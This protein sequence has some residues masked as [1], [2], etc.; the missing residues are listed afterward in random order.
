MDSDSATTVY[1]IGHSTHTVEHFL[2]LLQGAGITAVA[3]VRSQPF[4]RFNPQFN[5]DALTQ[6]L[7]VA[8]IAYVFVGRELGARS[9]DPACYDHGRVIYSRLAGTAAFHDGIERVL[10]GAEKYRVALMCAEKEPLECHRTLL[11]GRALRDRAVNVAHIHADGR[12]ESYEDAML[13]L[14]DITGLP[15]EDLF[16]SPAEL[17]QEALAKQ[18]L[19]VAY[20]D[21]KL[22]AEATGE[23]A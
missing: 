20:I 6:S 9:D 2:G 18:E 22:I 21:E 10:S 15:R 12:V 13:R 19:R 5:R 7:K 14:L 8:G 1:T 11:V 16:R 23:N 17:R 3:D 4:S